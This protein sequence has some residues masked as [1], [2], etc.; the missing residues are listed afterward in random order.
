MNQPTTP[1]QTRTPGQVDLPDLPKRGTDADDLKA[2]MAGVRSSLSS[3]VQQVTEN[4]RDLTD[5]RYYVR[6]HPLALVGAAAVAGYLAVP[7]WPK[8]IKPTDRQLEQMAR[9]G[10]VSLSKNAKPVA[11]RGL[12]DRGLSIAAAFA[13]RAATAYVS[14]QMGKFTGQAAGDDAPARS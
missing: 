8:V 11:S 2:R 10:H 3:D 7:S 12:I 13:A 5:W 4:A 6:Q 14:Q 9:E 1:N